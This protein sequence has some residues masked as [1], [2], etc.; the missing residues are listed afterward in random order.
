MTKR[1]F[2]PSTG[3]GNPNAVPP[4]QQPDSQAVT[5]VDARVMEQI[6]GGAP[7]E[8]GAVMDIPVFEEARDTGLEQLAAI[9]QRYQAQ[10]PAPAPAAAPQSPQGAGSMSATQGGAPA[11]EPNPFTGNPFL[12]K[13]PEQVA[14]PPPIDPNIQALGYAVQQMAANQAQGRAQPLSMEQFRLQPTDPAHQYVW[15]LGQRIEP[16]MAAAEQRQAALEAQIAQLNQQIAVSNAEA[17]F[18][19]QVEAGLKSF[20]QIPAETVHSIASTAAQ[21]VAMGYPAQAAL[22]QAAEPHLP[23]LRHIQK[24]SQSVTHAPLPGHQ[25]NPAAGVRQALGDPNLAAQ[26]AATA[27][28]GSSSAPAGNVTGRSMGLPIESL[29]RILGGMPS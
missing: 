11:T 23:M 15:D 27:L 1:A 24:L 17:R 3:S 28:G 6:L 2:D 29:E 5:P 18:R 21:L 8:P 12:P 10:P 20:G 19:P 22:A 25:P 26:M 16:Y 13:A 14:P 4:G 9:V 7:A